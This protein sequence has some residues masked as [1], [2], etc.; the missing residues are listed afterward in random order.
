[1]D[2]QVTDSVLQAERRARSYWDIDGLAVIIQAVAVL[3]A[4]LW[5]WYMNS[6]GAWGRRQTDLAAIVCI[7][8]VILD[9]IR[10][11]AVILWFKTKITYPRTG[12]V[13]PPAPQL[14]SPLD[15]G[16]K[17]SDLGLVCLLVALWAV[18]L[19]VE[20]PWLCVAAG[21]VTGVTL[22]WN[23][24]REKTT[25]LNLF[26]I[27]C[28]GMLAAFLLSAIH[29]VVHLQRFAY[30]LTALGML[31]LIKG[32]TTLLSYVRRNPVTQL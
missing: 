27:C 16:F 2:T 29:R 32:M 23:P 9:T 18:A 13:A 17:F 5:F 22:W 14:S 31:A 8:A 12:Y 24:A 7:V 21:I 19:W 30:I 26:G 10:K 28:A 20:T 4:G 3:L 11:P 25:Y 6:S 15:R 1:M